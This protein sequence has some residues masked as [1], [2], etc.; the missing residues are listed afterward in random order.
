[1]PGKPHLCAKVQCAVVTA[2]WCAATAGE[3]S[4]LQLMTMLG[5]GWRNLRPPTADAMLQQLTLMLQVWDRCPLQALSWHPL[6]PRGEAL[7]GHGAWHAVQAFCMQHHLVRHD[8]MTTMHLQLAP[9][10]GALQFV[11]CPLVLPR[12]RLRSKLCSH[13]KAK[14]VL[15]IHAPP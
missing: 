11:G 6:Q 12:S 14:Q 3:V 9:H 8:D 7:G 4:L 13:S 1:M 10:L 15:Q 2:A 5:P